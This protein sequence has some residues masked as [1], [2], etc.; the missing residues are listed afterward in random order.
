MRQQSLSELEE[1]VFTAISA[2]EA[3]GSI[4][5]TSAIVRET[6]L[7]LEDV[8]P[9]LHNLAEKSLLH[10]EEVPVDGLDFGPRWCVRQ[11]T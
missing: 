3:R 6:A 2:L 8:R 11:P 5:Y 7:P 10:R 1:R 4:P 9:V